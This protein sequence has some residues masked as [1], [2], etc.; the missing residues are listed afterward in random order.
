[1]SDA[2]YRTRDGDMLDYICWKHYGH[3][4]GSIEQTVEQ[5]LERNPGLASLGPVYH[6]N[7]LII[8]PEITKPVA[9][10]TIRIWD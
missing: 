2:T 1:M 5:T 7:I 6:E 8:L 10:P 4:T 9:A 3:S